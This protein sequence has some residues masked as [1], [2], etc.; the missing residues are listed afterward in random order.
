VNLRFPGQY[1][2]VEAGKHYDYFRG[3]DPGMG[4]YASSDPIG[5]AGGLSTYGYVGGNPLSFYDFF[6]LEYRYDSR[7]YRQFYDP[8]RSGCEQPIRRSGVIIGWE[9]CDPNENQL[10]P[11]GVCYNEDYKSDDIQDHLDSLDRSIRD[12]IA[13]EN[14][15]RD[16]QRQDQQ[17]SQEY[18]Y[19]RQA[20][21]CSSNFLGG[22]AK[23]GEALVGNEIL[24]SFS[25]AL[26]PVGQAA[27]VVDTGV[28][29]LKAKTYQICVRTARMSLGK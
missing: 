27:L 5:L 1:F 25:R 14:R 28:L 12:Q 2:D 6:G 8:R 10:P 16:K 15:R 21:Q 20:Q 18:D 23:S 29:A 17:R 19:F 9:P 13:E 4:R 24:A 11:S 22:L 26:H 7:D 3:Y